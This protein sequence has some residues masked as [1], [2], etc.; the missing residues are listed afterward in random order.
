MSAH[1]FVRPGRRQGPLRRNSYIGAKLLE[2]S[3]EQR[4]LIKKFYTLETNDIGY[5]E[6]LKAI[7]EF[8]EYDPALNYDQ[9]PI[10]TELENMNLNDQNPWGI[11]PNLPAHYNINRISEIIEFNRTKAFM[12]AGLNQFSKRI[13]LICKSEFNFENWIQ[14]NFYAF[15]IVS[16]VRGLAF[17]KVGDKLQESLLADI[18]KSGINLH[19][20]LSGTIETLAV[21]EQWVS[22]EDFKPKE[23]MV[24][25]VFG[26][27]YREM[28]S[29]TLPVVLKAE[30]PGA[31]PWMK[32]SIVHY[33]KQFLDSNEC[34]LVLKGAPGTGKTTFL[35][36]M[37]KAS[38][39]CAVVT[40]DSH[41]LDS[42]G[43]FASFLTRED[44]NLLIIED[45]DDLLQARS[46]GNK[47]VEKLLNAS[48]GMVSFSHKKLIFSTNLPNINMIDPALI[49]PGRCF[50]ILE[51]RRLNQE[52]ANVVA[53]NYYGDAAPKLEG[54]DF[55][56][57][58]ITNL[59]SSDDPTTEIPKIGFV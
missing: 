14:T 41:L 21:F 53:Q 30:I 47:L 9:K 28:E 51:F 12:L 48:D 55:S 42:D 56:L 46:E 36:Q 1:K 31:Y 59:R 2:P 26:P 38:E 29:Y 25:W 18:N 49:R 50:D 57:A 4:S 22:K 3:A 40:Y 37:I 10:E 33:T 20:E 15:N 43:F 54:K 52:E 16:G 44:A 58:E 45:A 13:S 7:L 32:S 8:P 35:K 11:Q 23:V 5:I 27:N 6:S 17:W 34:V 39:T 24:E 19:I